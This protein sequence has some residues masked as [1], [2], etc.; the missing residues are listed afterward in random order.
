MAIKPIIHP[1]STFARLDNATKGVQAAIQMLDHP[2]L[3]PEAEATYTA[4]LQ[5]YHSAVCYA[6][7]CRGAN[8]SIF[9]STESQKG[10]E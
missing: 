4:A 10:D 5:E 1:T 7:V 9:D 8:H 6:N 3:Y 2:S